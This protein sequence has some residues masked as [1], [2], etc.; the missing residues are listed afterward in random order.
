[1]SKREKDLSQEEVQGMCFSAEGFLFVSS[2][3]FFFMQIAPAG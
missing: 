2:L 3:P 1:M